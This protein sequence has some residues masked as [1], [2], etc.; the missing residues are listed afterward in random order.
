[1]RPSN[2]AVKA[3]EPEDLLTKEPIYRVFSN[4]GAEGSS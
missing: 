3:Q 2:L 4:P 1:M